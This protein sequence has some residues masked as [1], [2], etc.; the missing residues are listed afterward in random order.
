MKTTH[1]FGK[2]NQ[3]NSLLKSNLILRP[4]SFSL[5]LYCRITLKCVLLA[6]LNAN[7]VMKSTPSPAQETSLWCETVQLGAKSG[8]EVSAGERF[9]HNWPRI[10]RKVSFSPGETLKE[11]DR[12][13]EYVREAILTSERCLFTFFFGTKLP[14]LCRKIFGEPRGIQPGSAWSLCAL[15]P[16]RTTSPCPSTSTV[17]LEL[18]VII[19]AHVVW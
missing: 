10:R 7:C 11:A 17:S 15:P 18:Q 8:P 14:L 19:L 5:S 1:K 6:C 4:F 12:W 9:C 2:R 3:A 16:V 13:V